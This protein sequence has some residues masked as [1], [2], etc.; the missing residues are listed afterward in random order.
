M[1]ITAAWSKGRH[2]KYA[3]YRCSNKC[4]NASV[5]VEDLD[6]MIIKLLKDI[7]PTEKCLDLFITFL[8]KTY[9]ERISRLQ[10]TVA[11]ADGEIE[12][13]QQLRS[14]LVQKNLNGVYSDEVFK[15]QN[16]II[17]NKIMTA[18]VV[19]EDSMLDKYNIVDVTSFVRTLLADLGETY[20]RSNISQLKVLFGSMFSSGLSWDFNGTLNHTLSPIYQ[21]IRTFDNGAIQFGTPSRIRTGGLRDENAP[22]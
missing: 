8:Q 13:L 2:S 14:A 12:R 10:K 22:S 11:D 17:E 9:S 19:K 1:G 6:E 4:K 16:A 18:Q 21:S 5:K 3:Y 7:T 20:K 15:E